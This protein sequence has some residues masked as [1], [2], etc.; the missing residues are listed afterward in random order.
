MQTYQ[1]VTLYALPILLHIQ[2]TVSLKL[3][4]SAAGGLNH[5]VLQ[6]EYILEP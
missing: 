3:H 6:S 5:I 4:H 1:T 2:P